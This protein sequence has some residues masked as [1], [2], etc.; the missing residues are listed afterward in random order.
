M[1]SVNI[2]FRE[3][4]LRDVA[5]CGGRHPTDHEHLRADADH[6]GGSLLG[7]RGLNGCI[8]VLRVAPDDRHRRA[9]QLCPDGAR[10]LDEA[11]K[12]THAAA[13]PTDEALC[14]TKRTPSACSR[15]ISAR[16]M[17]SETVNSSRSAASLT[18]AARM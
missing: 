8:A 1:S 7:D 4:A 6:T 10:L 14:F 15:A 3:S 12:E 5:F 11:K 17:Y 2:W 9:G 18:A 13:A 16:R